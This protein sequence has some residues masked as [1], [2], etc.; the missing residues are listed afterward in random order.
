MNRLLK[1][2]SFRSDRQDDDDSYRQQV[3]AQAIDFLYRNLS[4]AVVGILRSRL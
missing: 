2:M 3:T 4:N 1:K